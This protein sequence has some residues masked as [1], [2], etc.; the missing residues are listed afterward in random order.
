ML[1]WFA[2]A[3]QFLNVQFSFEQ[4]ARRRPP[5]FLLY[6]SMKEIIYGAARDCGL[7]PVIGRVHDADCSEESDP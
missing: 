3:G 4:F 7:A 5:R 2:E 6:A 1:C